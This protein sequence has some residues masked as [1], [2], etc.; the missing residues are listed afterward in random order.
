MQ[1]ALIARDNAGTSGSRAVVRRAF[2]RSA[3][4][5]YRYLL[6]RVRG[7][8]ELADELLQ[9]TCVEASKSQRP[10]RDDAQCEAWLR[11]IA[12]NLVR[13]HWRKLRRQPGCVPLESPEA[14]RRLV[15]DLES[16]PL[17]LDTL[18][19]EEAVTQLML[20]VTSLSASDQRLIF[21]HYFERRSQAE[22]ARELSVSEKGVESRLYRLRG[23]LRAALRNVKGSGEP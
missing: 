15:D 11:G 19:R 10:P 16:R 2:L 21:A 8:R 13:R 3:D 9:Q 14:A 20:A 12:R 5:L 6:V 1:R 22:I 4:G 7:D 17:P 23:R 18:I